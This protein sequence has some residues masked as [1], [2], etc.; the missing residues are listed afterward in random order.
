MMI[1][2]KATVFLRDR[3]SIEER[4]I[5]SVVDMRQVSLKVPGINFELDFEG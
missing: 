2:K 3:G 5:C 1:K 4:I